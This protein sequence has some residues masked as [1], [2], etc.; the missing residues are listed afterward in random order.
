MLF[1]SSSFTGLMSSKAF[2]DE[3]SAHPF[4]P[5]G[6]A[7]TASKAAYGNLFWGCYYS[8][9]GTT[10][11]VSALKNQKP[12]QNFSVETATVS[13]ITGIEKDD[14]TMNCSSWTNDKFNNAMSSLGF[15]TN[16][17]RELYCDI[18]SI[19]SGAVT[20]ASTVCPASTG[21]GDTIDLN[22]SKVAE[23][24]LQ[25]AGSIHGYVSYY[26]GYKMLV[27]IGRAHV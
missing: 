14:D 17:P 24:I 16:S 9:S 2:A 10:Y 13:A 11:S 21:T 8:P 5:K 20:N 3:P 4:Y 27:Q 7:D 15:K 25:K 1:R 23:A 26:I 6:I 18:N 22:G 19:V 12:F